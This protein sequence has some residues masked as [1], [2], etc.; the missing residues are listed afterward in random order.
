MYGS[1]LTGICQNSNECDIDVDFNDG[2]RNANMTSREAI[3][4]ICDFLSEEMA[5]VFDVAEVTENRS[6]QSSRIKL[7]HKMTTA[8]N[9][10]Q[11][12]V[13]NFT[14]GLFVKAHRT[15]TLLRAYMDLDERAK[16]LAFALRYLASVSGRP[17]VHSNSLIDKIWFLL[18]RCSKLT[19]AS[20]QL[21]RHTPTP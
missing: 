11:T 17:F 16:V 5:H 15:S 19:E 20:Q 3:G 10:S 4:L 9:R 6:S 18:S 12:I 2:V 7:K 13:F 8:D 14:C 21:S 1:V